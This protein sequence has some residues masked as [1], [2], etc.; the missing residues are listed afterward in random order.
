MAYAE[1][2]DVAARW[3]RTPSDEEATLVE[4]RLAEVE[5]KIERRFKALG[6]GTIAD[7]IAATTLDVEDVKQVEADTVL[8]LVRNPEGYLSETDGNYTYMLQAGSNAGALEI[9]AEDWL[10][11]G[12]T[13]APRMSMLIPD[14]VIPQ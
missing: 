9:S 11:L 13:P 6:L 3:A 2:Q 12:V 10:T 7:Q 1:V 14:P 5:R 4:I 8:R